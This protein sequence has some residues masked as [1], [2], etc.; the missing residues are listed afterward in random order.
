[1]VVLL[2]HRVTDL[3]PEDGLTVNPARFRVMCRM[4]R[5]RFRIVPLAEMFRLVRTGSPIQHGT[6]A[7]TFDDSYRDNLDAA[8]VLAEH[9]LP[10][11]FFIPAGYVG[12]D[13]VYD[14]D[15]H[16][17]VRLPNLTWDDVIEMADMGFEIGSHT[18][19]HPNLADL[20]DEQARYELSESKKLLEHKL[21]R[22]VRYFAYPFGE[23]EHFRRE[24]LDLVRA[25]GYEGCVSAHGGFIYRHGDYT[26]LPRESVPY[27]DSVLNLELYLRG[28]LRWFYS[29]KRSL[30]RAFMAS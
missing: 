23:R 1:M 25:A 29:A 24:Q 26:I 16:F 19:T 3:I 17:T 9:G 27:F 20:T 6:A 13:Q 4:L 8:R 28:S 7:I 5:Q 14:W 2:F 12:T 21:G 11:T 18:M 22:P 15:R 30:L 10:A